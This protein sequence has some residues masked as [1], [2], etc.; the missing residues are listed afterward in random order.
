VSE[1]VRSDEI[2]EY[3]RLVDDYNASLFATLRH[4]RSSEALEIWVPDD[5]PAKSILNMVEAAELAGVPELRIRVGPQTLARLDV[6]ALEDAANRHGRFAFERDGERAVIAITQIGGTNERA[7]AIERKPAWFDA[8]HPVY[9]Q[10]IC[11]IAGRITH[12][13]ELELPHGTTRYAATCDGVTLAI[14]VGRGHTITAAAHSGTTLRTDR[15]VMDALCSLLPGLSVQEASDHG[16]QR[17]ERM[18]RANGTRPVAGIVL[19]ENADPAFVRPKR[20]VREIAAAYA[21]ETGYAP[22]QNNFT[23]RPS[24]TWLA[25]SRDEKLRSVQEALDG[26]A[27]DA[28]LAPGDARVVEIEQHLR[29]TVAFAEHVEVGRKPHAL[30]DLEQSLRRDLEPMLQLFSLELKDANRLRRLKEL[31]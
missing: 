18:L 13:G 11:A 16:A 17:L 30:M 4:H 31:S 10:A 19:P 26:A 25:L 28:G 8:V 7:E 1:A 5:D 3:E 22:G 24:R 2:L 12:E 20:L 6:D 21:R 15:A 14:A 27:D 29:A 9:R 23:S